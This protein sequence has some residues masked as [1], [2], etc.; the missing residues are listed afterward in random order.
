MLVPNNIGNTEEN[1]LEFNIE[2]ARRQAWEEYREQDY[3]QSQK[4]DL[5]ETNKTTK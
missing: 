2:E 3:I 5:L 4:V 1:K